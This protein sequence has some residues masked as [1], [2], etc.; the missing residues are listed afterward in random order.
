[1]KSHKMKDHAQRKVLFVFNG[2]VYMDEEGV[3]Y[4]NTLN[5]T[6]VEQYKF[7]GAHVSYLIRVQQIKKADI[8]GK[9]L[10]ILSK[11]FSVIPVPEFNSVAHHMRNKRK[12]EKIIKDAVSSHD[13]MICR[14]PSFLGR[15]TA[16][17]AKRMNKPYLI[18]VVACTWDALWNYNLF[19]KMLAPYG[20]YKLK[21]DMI[22]AP[23]SIYVTNE[24]LQRRYPS[25]G[26]HVGISDVIVPPR[27]ASV[28]EKRIA[29]INAFNF[30]RP[31]VIGTAAALDV[32]YKGQHYVIRALAA[33]RKQG[34]DFIYSPA[35][36]GDFSHLTAL[37][38][39][40]G[41]EDLVRIPGQIPFDE[42]QAYFDSLD[43]YVQPSRQEGL[44]RALA[45]ALSRG[46]PSFGS[47]TGGIPEL[48]SPDWIFEKGDVQGIVQILKSLTKE[49]MLYE[50][51]RA[52]ETGGLYE[53]EYLK[54]KR[55]DFYT[56]FMKEHNL[57]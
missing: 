19:G 53:F 9:L 4:E 10:P 6:I 13:V 40:L 45:E 48:L 15:R 49:K 47:R 51:K 11:N 14:L 39:E 32:P 3:Y 36:R 26:K 52:Y 37:A 16:L 25:R 28:L 50:A 33:L 54:K 41:V 24:W 2:P 55:E 1:M 43:L 20:F 27:D 5:D 22:N 17:W 34:L 21:K 46:C 56:M 23:Y 44:P 38:K 8:Q 35:G 29:K 7:F 31:L 18:E 42:I 12:I 57:I 30:D